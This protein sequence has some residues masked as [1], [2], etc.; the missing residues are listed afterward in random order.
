M[1]HTFM[2]KKFENNNT[3]Y[4][5]FMRVGETGPIKIGFTKN[6]RHRLSV[7]QVD[8]PTLVRLIAVT[9][10][11]RKEEFQ[12]HK[13]FAKYRLYGEWFEPS[14]ELLEYINQFPVLNIVSA[15]FHKPTR[16]GS[17]CHN[18]KGEAASVSSKRQRARAYTRHR[19]Q[20]ERCKL[21]KGLDTVYK[22]G[23]KDNLEPSNIV[24]YCRRCRMELDGTLDIFKNA[25]LRK[26][27]RPCKV[28]GKETNRFWYDRCHACNEFWRRNGYERT[29]KDLHP[30]NTICSVCSQ[31][32]DQLAKGRCHSCYE[33]FRRNGF[34]RNEINVES[35]GLAQLRLI[36][37]MNIEKASLIRKLYI[38]KRYGNKFL[39]K[40]AEISNSYFNDII[41]NRYFVD[42]DYV[43]QPNQ[44]RKKRY[45][46]DGYLSGNK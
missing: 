15:D 37:K 26:K 1:Y 23:N 5:Y 20:C 41:R 32:V 8:N 27:F 11:G 12:L 17:S 21:R 9:E 22:D 25:Q 3:S 44:N 6:V 14:T 7:V 42:N 29:E 13:R 35:E 18:W 16:K 34:D 40:Q 30:K 46:Q 33:F 31:K 36:S 4:V 39:A 28:C 24:L 43:Y 38:S 10:G 2:H 45:G 19:K